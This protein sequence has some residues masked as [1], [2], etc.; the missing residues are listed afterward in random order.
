MLDEPGT[1][2]D[3]E[4]HQILT[5]LLRD[6]AQRGVTV[7]VTSHVLE[8]LQRMCDRIHVLDAGRIGRTY[9]RA[10]FELLRADL[11]SGSL[12][13]RIEAAHRA[14]VYPRF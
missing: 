14:L 7:V 4:S 6:L 10:E 3:L 2:L 8:S 9:A 12:A 1:G 13:R 11:L 5:H